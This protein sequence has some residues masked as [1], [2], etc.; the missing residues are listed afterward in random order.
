VKLAGF[1]R[2]FVGFC[3]ILQRHFISWSRLRP[4]QAGCWYFVVQQ[5]S[6]RQ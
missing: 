4:W 1:S 2:H 3:V 6:G 5:G